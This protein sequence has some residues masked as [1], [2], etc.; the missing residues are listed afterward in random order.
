MQK[1]LDTLFTSVV[2][3]SWLFFEAFCSDLW[4]TTVDNAGDIISG[5]VIAYQKW[6]KGEMLASN[7]PHPIISKAKTQPGSYR[8]DL[9]M[10]SFQTLR[11]IKQFFKAAFG[12]NIG[13]IFD[14]TASGYITA[15]SEV[16]NC[17]THRAG[18]V[19]AKF[20][21]NTQGRF[22]EFDTLNVGDDLLLDGEL[23]KKLR[24]AAADTGSE[25]LKT[26][27]EMLLCGD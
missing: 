27:D 9:E 20:K 5:R 22:S 19:D 26:V 10:V 15:L 6:E 1:S 25:L 12:D 16:R 14:N 11:S 13:G 2:L 21:I 24:N 7:I 18:K 3:E 8:R 23:V 17:I 4:V